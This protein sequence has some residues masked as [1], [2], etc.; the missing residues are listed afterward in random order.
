MVHAAE[1]RMRSG[2]EPMAR[3][4]LPIAATQKQQ[5]RTYIHTY[6]R[7]HVVHTHVQCHTHC[8][9]ADTVHSRLVTDIVVHSLVKQAGHARHHCSPRPALVQAG[10]PLTPCL[11]PAD[12]L[13]TSTCTR[14]VTYTLYHSLLATHNTAVDKH[15]HT[16][17][18]TL[19]PH[20]H[21]HTTLHSTHTHCSRQTHTHT[22][23]HSTLQ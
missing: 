19:Q 21:T 20:M 23:T 2:V 9:H 15:T 11:L 18:H 12:A 14:T 10:A 17:T 13:Y 1:P 4:H 16:H 22:H 5:V 6:S 7:I 3:L 8:T